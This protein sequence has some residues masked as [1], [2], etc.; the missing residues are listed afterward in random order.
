MDYKT[1]RKKDE[2]WA[3][4]RKIFHACTYLLAAASLGTLIYLVDSIGLLE[5]LKLLIGR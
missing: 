1:W 4:N 2:E 5:T 3:R